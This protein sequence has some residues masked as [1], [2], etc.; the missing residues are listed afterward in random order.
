MNINETIININARKNKDNNI[1]ALED[2][3]KTDKLL[4]VSQTE[5]NK[6]SEKIY[7]KAFRTKL[8]K[9]FTQN[10]KNLI[11]NRIKFNTDKI[12]SINERLNELKLMLK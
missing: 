3:I 4:N 7:I 11:N 2:P 8:N 1:N 9:V 5:L 12:D 10:N 6:S